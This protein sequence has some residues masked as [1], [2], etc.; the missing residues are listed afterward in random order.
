MRFSLPT[1]ILV[2]TLLGFA[3]GCSSS[4]AN[5]AVPNQSDQS[6][7]LTGMSAT[8][9]E[10]DNSSPSSTSE[11][12]HQLWGL[13]EIVINPDEETMEITPMRIANF[14][15]NA[16]KFLEPGG[17]PGGLQI[18]SPLS[19][20]PDHKVLDVDLRIVHPF[21]SSMQYSGFDVKGIFISNGTMTGFSDTEMTLAGASDTR[22]LNADGLTR[23]WNPKEF[24]KGGTMF[25]YKD[26]A[27]GYKDSQWHFSST[28]NGFKYFADT[29]SQ[30]SNLETLNQT[31]RGAFRAGKNNTR[32]YKIS[33]N[34]GAKFNYAIDASWAPPSENPPD[35]PDDFPPEANQPEPWRISAVAT[36]NTLYYL[37][38]S[39]GGEVKLDIRVYDWQSAL[40]ETL[41]GTIKSVSIE[42]PG[43]FNATDAAYVSDMGT[44]ALWQATIK[45]KSGAL[46]SNDDVQ[47]LITAKSTDGAG[48][49]GIL[50]AD[51]LLVSA[52]AFTATV[53][54]KNPPPVIIDG[55]TGNSAPA[56]ITE[57]YEVLANDP[58]GDTL[59]Y[60]WSVE[61]KG[62][63][64]VFDDPGNGDGT[65]DINWG[66]LGIGDYTVQA[67]VSDGANPAVQATPL[68]VTVG[69]T[70]PQVGSVTGSTPVTSLDKNEQYQAAVVDPDVPP[71]VLT[72][73]WSIVNEGDPENFVLASNPDGSI[74]VD[75]S[76]HNI[77]SYDVNVKVSDGFANATGTKL[78]VVK[79]N[80]PPVV[81][82][83]TGP[84]PV[85][86]TDTAS[87]YNA[88]VTEYDP[89]QTPVIMWSV[90][91]SGNADAFVIPAEVDGTLIQDWS[92]VPAGDYDVNVQ[93]DDSF[94]KVTSTALI[95]TKENTPPTTSSVSGPTLVTVSDESVYTLNPEATDCDAGDSL[96]YMFSLVPKGN[97]ANYNLP[98]GSGS[99]DVV[100]SDY[101]VG[102][103]TIGCRISDG[104]ANVFA[105]TL[106]VIVAAAPCEGHAH[107]YSAPLYVTGYSV[108]PTKDVT[109]I[110]GT[111]DL[112]GYGVTQTGP[113]TLGVFEASSS[114]NT[115]V[116]FTYFLGKKDKVMSLDSEPVTGRLLAVTALDPRLIKIIDPTVIFGQAIIGTIQTPESNVSWVA[117]DTEKNG[118]FWGL[119]RLAGTS[120][121]YK[122][123]HYT[124]LEESPW[125]QLDS[126]GATFITEKVGTDTDIFDIAIDQNAGY[127]YVFEVGASGKGAVH[128]YKIVPG[129]PLQFQKTLGNV[130]NQT[131]S[132][133]IDPSETWTAYGDIDLDHENASD[134]DCRILV[135]GRFGNGTVELRRLDSSL[136]LL[137]TEWGMSDCT[138]FAIN[139]KQNKSMRNLLMPDIG[140]MQFWA[141]PADW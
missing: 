103:Y 12:A 112:K 113:S 117:T 140:S 69:N 81:G 98:G 23:W 127:L 83:I 35:V 96:T 18:A 72:Y 40:P 44:Y 109:F 3:I 16:L 14:H 38:T 104:T 43:L 41:G 66:T 134:E 21:P 91:A 50:D 82:E 115:N 31:D 24:T 13:Y 2:L 87:V 92:S 124:Y 84:N 78:T 57:K 97:P 45:P 73:S 136:N 135:Y 107:T 59:T 139:P 93:V 15:L 36:E 126:S 33:F 119:Q 101:G 1:L 10:T 74:N 108:L 90:V 46:K 55:V 132:F 32:H 54:S 122:L 102:E 51:D 60:L 67:E 110:E 39:Q 116:L 138:S 71:Q 20:S 62:N 130:F 105:T 100:W 52:N 64:Y 121:T 42:W 106:N 63:P 56:P 141:P 114:G 30:T 6:S 70:P 27:Y 37:G 89:G 75:W 25:S 65:I 133:Q 86:C 77:G 22:L 80:M 68:D 128:S 118:G 53:S 120:V 48:Y 137:D 17:K 7:N 47:F 111:E 34:G 123:V 99:I 88:S 49:G 4:T 19:F 94:V 76:T 28:M 129:G 125:F 58:N 11:N 29:L 5:P 8:S 61:T 131:L 26:G 85:S 79:I 95:V 9:D